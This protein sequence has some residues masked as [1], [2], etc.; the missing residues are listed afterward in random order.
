V[1]RGP[2]DNRTAKTQRGKGATKN[3][4]FYHEGREEHEVK[5]IEK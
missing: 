2:E 5:K 4:K 3:A 1:Q